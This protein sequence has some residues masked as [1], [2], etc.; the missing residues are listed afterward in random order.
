MK[1]L[2]LLILLFKMKIAKVLSNV[3]YSLS[4]RQAGASMINIQS[5]LRTAP[6]LCKSVPLAV[7]F[8]SN[9]NHIQSL[10]SQMRVFIYIYIYIDRHT[11]I[12]H[13]M[14]TLVGK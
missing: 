5:T 4:H 9:S 13:K 1:Y 3:T 12:L 14:E 10:S 2:V 7:L 11:H 8:G 6:G